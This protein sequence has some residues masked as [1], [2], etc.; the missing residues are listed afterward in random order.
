MHAKFGISAGWALAAVVLFSCGGGSDADEKPSADQIKDFCIKNCQKTLS[1]T[2]ITLDCAG[3]CAKTNNGTAQISP[4]CNTNA[5]LSKLK[6]CLDEDCPA[7]QSCLSNATK[8]C[9]SSGTGGSGNSTGGSSNSTGGAGSGDCSACSKNPACCTAL[10]AQVGQDPAYCS[11]ATVASCM[12]TAAGMAQ[13][14]VVQ[15]CQQIVQG[16]VA[17]NVAACK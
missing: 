13:T 5:T 15:A 1:C 11:Q 8:A 4:A 12:A 10:A 6:G 2:G 14:A 3:E 9:S 17:L 7:W 16:G